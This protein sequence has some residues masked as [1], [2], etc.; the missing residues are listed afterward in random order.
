MHLKTVL[1]ALGL[2][3]IPARAFAQTIP[4]TTYPAGKPV[5]VS[6]ASDIT[7]STNAV[8]VSNNATVTYQ[9]SMSIT[10]GPGFHA[11]TGSNFYAM[12]GSSVDSDGDGLPD[13]W[14][15]A[16]GLNPSSAA[17]ANNTTSG[18]LTYSQ[19]ETGEVR[20]LLWKSTIC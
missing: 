8:T 10:L 18:G 14:E 17:D 6:G 9:A 4:P 12:I 1:L 7:T 2:L 13:V 3:A 15:R 5:V 20:K 19:W 16:H 11:A